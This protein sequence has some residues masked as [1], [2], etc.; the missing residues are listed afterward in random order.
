L[1]LA[2]EHLPGGEQQVSDRVF[3]QM[4][5]KEFEFNR[6][7]YYWSKQTIR[8]VM[9]NL[10][11]EGGVGNKTASNFEESVKMH[12]RNMIKKYHDELAFALN[13]QLP[14][15]KPIGK[16][17]ASANPAVMERRSVLLLDPSS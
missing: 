14:P 17:T 5:V 3:E 2:Q 7:L 15:S 6:Q 8:N 11:N 12:N 4:A 9:D 13:Y 10:S 16:Q 1:N